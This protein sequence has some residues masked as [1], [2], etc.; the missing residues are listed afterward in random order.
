[1][2][3]ES[4]K[5][6]KGVVMKVSGRMDAENAHE[7][8]SACNEWITK[9]ITCLILD[10]SGL[11]YVSSMGLSYFLAAAKALHEKAGTLILCRLQ[12]SPRQVFELTRLIGLFT[13]FDTVEGAI[14]TL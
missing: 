12:G 13:V 1:M 8:Q 2:Q 4:V 6:D 5:L 11:K 14:A 7:F 9:G 3:I 10:L